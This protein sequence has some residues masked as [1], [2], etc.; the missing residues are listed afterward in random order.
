MSI[1]RLIEAEYD[2]RIE[3]ILEA[4]PDR[5]LLAGTKEF[6]ANR[7]FVVKTLEAEWQSFVKTLDRAPI[8]IPVLARFLT[9][10]KIPSSIITAALRTIPK[11]NE[12]VDKYYNNE[13]II[14]NARASLGNQLTK[15]PSFDF[16]QRTRALVS[17]I[18]K[19]NQNFRK[20]LFSSR[21]SLKEA[22]R[23]EFVKLMS[24]LLA[25]RFHLR[26]KINADNK[27]RDPKDAVRNAEIKK[28]EG[29]ANLI[30]KFLDMIADDLYVEDVF[31]EINKWEEFTK[32]QSIVNE[33]ETFKVPTLKTNVIRTIFGRVAD[34]V[35]SNPDTFKKVSAARAEVARDIGGDRDSAG[36]DWGSPS[37]SS[38]T[39]SSQRISADVAN[40]EPREQERLL[41]KPVVDAALLLIRANLADDPS[42]ETR[43]KVFERMMT[44]P[45]YYATKTEKERADLADALFAHEETH[46]KKKT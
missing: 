34:N 10:Y 17:E 24:E 5:P 20:G 45:K 44:E 29:T 32:E 7:R 28:N 33:D 36:R 6:D 27:S 31:P 3:T 22:S 2:G 12:I 1:L 26:L 43:I 19:A 13:A 38:R 25:I 23:K 21:P 46:L 30:D 37:Y 11:H 4:E 14:T 8:T 16:G 42:L 41:K 18:N 40:R 9:R 35:L 39:S 15:D